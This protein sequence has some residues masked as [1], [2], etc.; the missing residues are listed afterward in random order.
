[1]VPNIEAQNCEMFIKLEK[2][3]WIIR[4]VLLFSD[5][6]FPGGSFAV[7][8]SESSN[9]A[10]VPIK[11]SKSTAES[12]DIRLLIGAG[13]NAQFFVCHQIPSASENQAYQPSSLSTIKPIDQQA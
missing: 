7:H 10:K 13:I 3:G 9:Q 5:T 8:L 11:H 2:P 4:S 12:M 1:M 6:L